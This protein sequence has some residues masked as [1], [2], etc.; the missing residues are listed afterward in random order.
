MVDFAFSG[1]ELLDDPTTGCFEPEPEAGGI[2]N[3]TGSSSISG[4]QVRP[5]LRAPENEGT[6]AAAAG[7]AR[8]AAGGGGERTSSSSSVQKKPVFHTI[9][10][11]ER[12]DLLQHPSCLALLHWKWEA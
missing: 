4:L 8:G 3:N 7:A 12:L 5:T 1:L 9:F 10:A 11:E 6:A 2:N